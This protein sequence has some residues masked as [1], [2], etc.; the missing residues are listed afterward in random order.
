LAGWI[1]ISGLLLALLCFSCN[2]SCDYIGDRTTYRMKHMVSDY[3]AERQDQFSKRMSEYECGF[4]QGKYAIWVAEPNFGGTKT[5]Y[6][7]RDG[8]LLTTCQSTSTPIPNSAENREE[9]RY[10][11][12]VRFDPFREESHVY[13]VHERVNEHSPWRETGKTSTVTQEVNMAHVWLVD[14]ATDQVL[15]YKELL[16]GGAIGGTPHHIQN[17]VLI[18]VQKWI[19]SHYPKH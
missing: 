18:S 14:T 6:H 4:L 17:R 9:I 19:E 13:E 5:F 2:L 10:I 15:A 16:P 12:V 8:Y 1:K 11:V 3:V 7:T